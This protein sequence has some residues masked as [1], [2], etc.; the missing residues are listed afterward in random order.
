MGR[1][2]TI[3][4]DFCTSELLAECS[5]SARLLFALMW[6]H[7]DDNGIHQASIRRLKIKVFPSDNVSN[8]DVQGYVQELIH[9]KLLSYY[10]VDGVG[11]WRV[12]QWEK[13]D[14]SQ[15]VDQPTFVF[16]L[17]TGEIPETP[18]RRG[19]G[20]RSTTVRRT[21]AQS[22]S[23][24]D[25]KD[26]F[27]PS[28]ETCKT[29]GNVDKSVDNFDTSL[30]LNEFPNCVAVIQSMIGRKLNRSE[31]E[32]VAV[33]CE[34]YDMQHFGLPALSAAMRRFKG[35][36]GGLPKTICYFDGALRDDYARV[37]RRMIAV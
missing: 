5:H 14:F 27:T 36:T 13:G 19:R 17:P 22:K 37:G 30:N 24:V 31:Q 21:F 3:K 9:N 7:C 33:W 8:D 16:P 2:R 28:V 32:M 11:Y 1:H 15:K 29:Q 23:R 35:R 25:S 34:N 12:N 10:E 26:T 6:M 20:E 4:P 18:P